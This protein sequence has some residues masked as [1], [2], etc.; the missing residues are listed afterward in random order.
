MSDRRALGYRPDIDGLRCVAV[1]T[2]LVYHAVPALCPGG[3]IGVDVF[4]VISGFL[5]TAI[6]VADQEDGTFS[7]LAFYGRRLRRLGPSLA[8]TLVATLALGFLWLGPDDYKVL[9]KTA[10]AA[11]WFTSNFY[12]AEHQGY[13]DHVSR[14]NALLHTWSL[15]IEEQFYLL[16]PAVL[17]LI[18]R[19]RGS[20]LAILAAIAA[21]SFAWNVAIHAT[22]PTDDFFLLPSRLWELAVGGLV[23]LTPRRGLPRGAAIEGILGALLIAGSAGLLSDGS[24]YPGWWAAAPVLGSSLLIRAGMASPLNRHL[25]AAAPARFIGGIS[26]QLY[27]W[28]WPLLVIARAKGL[29]SGRDVAATLLL[30][31][32]LAWVTR[33]FVE[34]PFRFALAGPAALYRFAVPTL[35]GLLLFVALAASLSIKPQVHY[36]LRLFAATAPPWART[37]WRYQFEFPG[38]PRS[39]TCFLAS[40]DTAQKFTADCEGA[41]P[42]GSPLVF[43]WGDSHAAAL[44]PGLDA[45]GRKAGFR[46]AQFTATACPPVLGMQIPVRPL[47]AE[48]ND[49]IIAKIA[50]LRPQEVVLTARWGQYD[51]RDA[52]LGR[53]DP[54]AVATTLARLRAAGVPKIVVVG[55]SP[56]WQRPL[57]R[58][59]IDYYRDHPAAAMP[60]RLAT[61]LSDEAPGSDGLLATLARQGGAVYASPFT[62]MCGA[63]G[64]LTVIPGLTPA[65]PIIWDEGH[66]TAAGARFIVTAFES[67]FLPPPVPRAQP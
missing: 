64:C 14:N 17:L 4:F 30:T 56:E 59:M 32:L 36:Q 8:I 12:I 7:F 53:L 60:L 27:L 50:A 57:P 15:G 28:H 10:K 66:L 58:I 11:A 63:G 42:P 9:A 19:W 39:H 38:F 47:C 49:F 16:W 41:G 29:D 18:R 61:G 13:W 23:A 26:Y 5:I 20:R 6:I 44:F 45:L 51:G 35:A 65:E 25:L 33:R 52:T 54:G 31:A 62:L 67:D 1:L 48:L 40:K 37:L 46:V 2:V 21:A 55:P 34:P 22:A 24:I 43:L 3:F